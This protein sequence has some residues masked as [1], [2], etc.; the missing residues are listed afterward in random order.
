MSAPEAVSARMDVIKLTTVGAPLLATSLAIFY[1]VGFFYAINPGFFTFFSVTEHLVFAL[2]A[3]PFALIPALWVLTM[4]MMLFIGDRIILKTRQELIEQVPKMSPDERATM[5][6]KATKKIRLTNWGFLVTVVINLAL[7]VF[8]IRIGSYAMALAAVFA[9]FWVFLFDWPLNSMPFERRLLFGVVCL[10]VLW[11]MAF[12]L[13][14]ERGEAVINSEPRETVTIG[15]DGIPS[16]LVRVG[17]RGVLFV[18]SNE[19][20]TRF[21]RWDDVKSIETIPPTSKP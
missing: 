17:E 8:L 10:S 9:C 7:A 5:L 2:Q 12:A 15:D 21:A 6:Q 20:K 18:V 14:Y 13:G 19:K 3:L 16:R 4:A 11:G 1:D